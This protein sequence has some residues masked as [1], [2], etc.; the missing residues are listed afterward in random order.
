M[1]R[2]IN[3]PQRCENPP[4]DGLVSRR[5]PTSQLQV[6]FQSPGNPNLRSRQRPVAHLAHLDGEI[7]GQRRAD[8]QPKVTGGKGLVLDHGQQ[9]A[10]GEQADLAAF[11]AQAEHIGLVGPCLI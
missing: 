5:R 2:R 8:E 9:V 1:I 3:S 6:R 10:V 11:S 7:I 4:Y